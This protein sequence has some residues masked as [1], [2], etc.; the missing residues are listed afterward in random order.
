[1]D[2]HHGILYG[3]VVLLL[4]LQVASFISISSQI[5]QTNAALETRTDSLN[6]SLTWMIQSSIQ[7]EQTRN[8]QTFSALRDALGE[9][10]AFQDSLQEDIELLK[11][12]SGDFSAVISEVVKGVVSVGTDKSM[13]TGFILTRS[14]YV[15]TNEH[16]INGA[17]RIEI[18]TSDRKV[19]PAA[20]VGYDTTRDVALLKVEGHFDALELET[21]LPS[22]GNKVIAI[23]NPLGLAFTVTEGIVSALDRKGPNGQQEY[24][25]T[26]VSLNPGN[27]GGPLINT[28]GKV[29]GMNNFKVGNAE[30]LGFALEAKVVRTV[31]NT[32]ANAT[33]LS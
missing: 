14:G 29:V 5:T 19:I 33:I 16:V 3:M 4:G 25:Q 20:L 13:G 17:R 23:G 1:M 30:S 18:L 10:Q 32:L 28:Q 2:K 11:T 26:D 22:V 12:S 7:E 9:Q 31:V 6:N 8:Q 24:I 27:S 21:H 15:V